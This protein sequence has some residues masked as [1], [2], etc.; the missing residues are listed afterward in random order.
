M[1]AACKYFGVTNREA[2]RILL[3]QYK[4]EYNSTDV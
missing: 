3:L 1:A 4:L 2:L